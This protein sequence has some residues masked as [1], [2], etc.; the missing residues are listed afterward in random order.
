[1]K[2]GERD[3][4]TEQHPKFICLLLVLNGSIKYIKS[5][6]ALPSPETQYADEY[7]RAGLTIM[8][9]KD[10]VAFKAWLQENPE[11]DIVIR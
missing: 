11:R 3:P 4:E 1:M 5:D 6:E 8:H 9:V 10:L 2:I 7:Q